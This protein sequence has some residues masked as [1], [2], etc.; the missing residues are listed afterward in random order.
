MDSQH[1]M[2][3]FIF[4]VI[5]LIKLIILLKILNAKKINLFITALS[6]LIPRASVMIMFG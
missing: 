6:Q 1:L 5:L 2:V 4:R 3:K